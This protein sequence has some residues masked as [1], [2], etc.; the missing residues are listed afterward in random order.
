[1]GYAIL[2][3]GLVLVF[4]VWTLSGPKYRTDHIFDSPTPSP[5]E[6]ERRQKGAR[7]RAKARQEIEAM[8]VFREHHPYHKSHTSIN[9][10]TNQCQWCGLTLAKI[11]TEKLYCSRQWGV[12]GPTFSQLWLKMQEGEK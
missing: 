10:I 5:E 2:V 3:F 4:V 12:V 6:L 11:Y 7:I 1:M 8:R 9:P